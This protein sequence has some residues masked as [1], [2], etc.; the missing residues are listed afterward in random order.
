MILI[1]EVKESGDVESQL[2][3]VLEKEKH[4]TQ[5][6]HAVAETKQKV[7]HSLK[8]VPFLGIFYL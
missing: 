5:T 2:R 6:T 7:C 4:Q 1:S 3:D 8:K